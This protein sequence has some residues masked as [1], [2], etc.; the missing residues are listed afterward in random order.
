MAE[1][2]VRVNLLNQMLEAQKN[3]EKISSIMKQIVDGKETE[4]EIKGDR[5]FYYKDRA[6][7]PNDCELRKAILDV[8][9]SGSFAIHPG[10][11]KMYQD[12]KMSFW[13]S[14]M[15]KRCIRICNQV[16]DVSKSKGIA[17]SSF[18]V[19]AAYQNIGVEMG[20]NHHGLCGWVTI[21]SEEA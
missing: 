5:S 9:H 17:S 4:F 13:W 1:L 20:P 19:I 2:I 3:D 21:D 15:K 11:T 14:G 10:S 16:F 8:A 18:R 6:C 7:V 12:F